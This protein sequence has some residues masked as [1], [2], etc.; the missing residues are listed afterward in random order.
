VLTTSSP[1]S[2][3][4]VSAVQPFLEA[5]DP[6]AL[7]IFLTSHYQN[8]DLCKLLANSDADVVKVAALALG[9][10]GDRLCIPC[11]AG[12]LCDPDPM[13]NQMAEH[14]L[15]N[16][17]FR[18]GTAA[19]NQELCL[20][21]HCLNDRDFD[22]AFAHFNRALE[23]SPEFAEAFHQRGLAWS[24]LDQHERALADYRRAVEMMPCHFSA[25]AGL[26]QCY[27]MLEKIPQAIEAYEQARELNPHIDGIGQA[28]GDL[29][30][31]ARRRESLRD[32]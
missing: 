9:M 32:T 14:A 4:F 1:G 6:A 12:R 3:R 20:G 11:L 29:R 31:L 19:A 22:C 25:W 17:W 5:Q 27:S 15:W 16:V 28:L 8:D 13:I 24:M 2:L 7:R 10:V 26:G 30:R 18:S 23:L 21:T